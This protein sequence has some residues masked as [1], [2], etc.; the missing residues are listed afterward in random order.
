MPQDQDQLSKY[1]CFKWFFFF[2]YFLFQILFQCALSKWVSTH[3]KCTIYDP[4]HESETH[5][6]YVH[7]KQPFRHL[8]ECCL[9]RIMLHWPNKWYE[10]YSNIWCNANG[11]NVVVATPFFLYPIA[12]VLF[13]WQDSP[14]A[15]HWFNFHIIFLFSF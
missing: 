8:G 4:V 1:R 2:I 11:S 3:T 9:Q 7:W 13:G 15:S 14:K 6:A 12:M 5:D 10:I